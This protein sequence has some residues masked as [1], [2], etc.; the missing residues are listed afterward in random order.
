MMVFVDFVVF[1]VF[2]FQVG[3]ELVSAGVEVVCTGVLVEVEVAWR[4]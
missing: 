3:V 2:L 1:V 4:G